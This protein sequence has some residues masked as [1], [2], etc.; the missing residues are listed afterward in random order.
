MKRFIAILLCASLLFMPVA[1]HADG[2]G[3]IDNGGGG[4]GNGTKGNIWHGDDGVRVTVVRA[5]DNKPV[6][7][8]ID[9]TKYNEKNVQYYFKKDKLLYRSGSQLQ[10]YC[11][12]YKCVHPS[13]AMPKIISDSGNA[14]LAAIKKYFCASETVKKIAQMI[15]TT[16]EKLTDGQYKLLLEPVAYFYFQGYKYAMT[17]T[18]AAKYDEALAGGL[19]RKMV[20]LTHQQLPLSMFLQH[21]DMGYPAYSGSTRRPQTDAVILHELGLGIVYF[22]D[23]PHPNPKPVGY[24]AT[25]RT[26][27][28]VITSVTLDTDSEIDPDSPAKVTFHILGSTYTRTEVVVPEGRN[29]LVWVKWHTP[30]TPQTIKITVTASK[31]TLEDNVVNAHIVALTEKTPPDPTATDR[32][33]SFK[34][35]DAPAQITGASN[36]WSV[37]SARWIADW[38]WEEHWVWEKHKGWSSGGEWVDKGKWVD[39]GYWEYD[40]TAYR[41][42]LSADMNL[43]PDDKDPT[44]QGKVMKSGYGV[45]IKISSG[46]RTS[47]STRNITG[48]QTAVTYFPE[49]SYSA[50]WRVLDRMTNGLSSPFAFKTNEYST[51]D[52]RVHFT[53]VWYPDGK[54]AAYTVLEDA[55][56]PAGMLSVK[57]TDDVTIDGS[58]Y[59]DWHVGPKLVG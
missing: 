29:Q 15:G 55:W 46:M 41:A 19:R 11:G 9:L 2:S 10:A 14:N 6:S 44:A 40:R 56:T 39:E 25:Y 24:D 5:S 17:A 49:F 59:D 26:N 3:N 36:T 37:W 47:A 31:G 32:N 38:E 23:G 57:L 27:T 4:M 1:A 21:S 20:S 54:Y 28:D 13:K 12:N 50:Y 18:E 22:K 52:R 16:Y 42:I 53:P 43:M 51:Y 48:A 30:S 35:P 58:V 8:P 34:V 45:K 7:T 33:D